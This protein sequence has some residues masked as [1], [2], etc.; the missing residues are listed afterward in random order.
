MTTLRVLAMTLFL[1]GA[2]SAQM[3]TEPPDEARIRALAAT[4]R[5]PVC[6]SESLL[7]SRAPTALEMMTIL[8]EQV[9]EGRSDAD[10]VTYFRNRYGDFVTLAP[11]PGPLGWA[12]WALPGLLLLA[13]GLIWWRG[14]RRARP[15]APEAAPLDRAALER[16]EP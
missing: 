15:A 3:L 10:I 2:A 16:M 14:V 8:R 13:G 6:Q 12:I 11:P 4:L 5:C 9:A 7:E 1:T